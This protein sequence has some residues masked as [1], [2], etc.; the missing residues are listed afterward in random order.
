MTTVGKHVIYLEGKLQD[1]DNE[2]FNY[3]PNCSGQL[4]LFAS[5]GMEQLRIQP[6]AR[7]GRERGRRVLGEL[8]EKMQQAMTLNTLNVSS[9]KCNESFLVW[10]QG[11]R[12]LGA[13]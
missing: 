3:N 5:T 13:S 2:L 4:F 8:Q 12:L 11:Q 6:A 1:H 9:F 10:V 7:Q